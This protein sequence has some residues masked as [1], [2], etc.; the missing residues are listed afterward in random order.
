MSVGCRDRLGPVFGVV[1]DQA[2]LE[3]RMALKRESVEEADD[4]CSDGVLL[5]PPSHWASGIIQW[6]WCNQL[7]DWAQEHDIVAA[8]QGDISLIENFPGY[9]SRDLGP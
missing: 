1:Y 3:Q 6:C 5:K 9:M 2:A 8:H 7:S 4:R